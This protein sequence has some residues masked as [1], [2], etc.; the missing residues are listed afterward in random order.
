VLKR[1]HKT[2]KHELDK[3]TA[4][5]EAQDKEKNRRLQLVESGNPLYHQIISHL[6][7]NVH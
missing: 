1:D 2:C 3:E 7:V 4:R 6:T 5:V